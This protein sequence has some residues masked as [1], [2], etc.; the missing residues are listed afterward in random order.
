LVFFPYTYEFA[1][2]GQKKHTLSVAQAVFEIADKFLTGAGDQRPVTVDAIALDTLIC[3]N[4]KWS[5]GSEYK[6][7]N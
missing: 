2:T 3:I 6:Q 1:A 7:G 4:T 5:D